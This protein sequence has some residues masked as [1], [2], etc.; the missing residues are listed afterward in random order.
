MK[1]TILILVAF[2][3]LSYVSYGQCTIASNTL[4]GTQYLGAANNY[5]VIFKSNST[6]ERMRIL[7]NNGNVG[8]GNTAP[9]HK[10]KVTGG[11][12]WTDSTFISTI[13][14]GT[15]PLSV[16]SITLNANLNADLLDGYHASNFQTALTGGTANYITKWTG[17][18][19]IGASTLIFDNGTNVGIGTTSP[20]SLLHI[21][22]SGTGWQ[23]LETME[24]PGD[25][26]SGG[27]RMVLKNSVS[28]MVITAYGTIT[29]M[30]STLSHATGISAATG[31]KLMLGSAANMTL[32][33][34]TND[35][36]LN[37]AFSIDLTGKIGL[38][39]TSPNFLVDA[40]LG[41]VASNT[42][43]FGYNV[44]ADATGNIGYAG[45]NLQLNNS[46]ANVTGY[47]RLARTSATTYLG[48][49]L[50][51]Q[52][53]DGIR[54]LTDATTPTEKMRITNAGSVGIGTTT[55]TAKL[56]VKASN[57]DPAIIVRNQN[58]S[59]H[60]RVRANGYVEARD[61]LVRTKT[62][63][64]F[65][66]YV[67]EKNYNLKSLN[68]VENYINTNKHLP[69]VPSASDV[70]KEGLN[71]VDMDVALLKKVEELT[72]YVIELQKQN[73]EMQKQNTVMQKEIELIKNK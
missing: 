42:T 9:N 11:S 27:T 52:S 51:S 26:T 39:T 57:T 24:N 38:G 47:L 34:Y 7:S 2:L 66:D 31:S 25:P 15:A 19:A 70:K 8:I 1:K 43:N 28:S 72:L 67:F 53:R 13:V 5:D 68:E 30:S 3:M 56:E 61:I 17:A 45:Y 14:T 21:Y 16:N 71:L 22:K 64:I 23:V 29:G 54:F 18:N 35:S 10:I 60:F 55:P 4:N 73:D 59:I 46:T 50:A 40:K 20:S 37:P 62:D 6:T 69:E 48:M 58:D 32:E 36:Y 44:F 65:P 12:V 33:M 41:N 63:L 49:E